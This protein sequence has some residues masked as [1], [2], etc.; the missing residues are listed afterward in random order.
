MINFD[1]L[2]KSQKE[3][4]VHEFWKE[5]KAAKRFQKRKLIMDYLANGFD[6]FLLVA[7][8]VFL[9]I[10][11][12]FKLKAQDTEM[13]VIALLFLVFVYATLFLRSVLF[14][15]IG[16]RIVNR[17]IKRLAYE[18]RFQAWAR[19]TKQIAYFPVFIDKK[20]ERMYE[21]INIATYKL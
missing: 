21:Q 13:F 3:E 2:G 16:K 8:G 12:V 11:L 9:I 5:D 4:L 18:K 10:N 20:D 1:S 14:S 19:D 17:K 6:F 7:L 15:I